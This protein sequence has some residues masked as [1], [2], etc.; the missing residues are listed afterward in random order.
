MWGFWLW[1]IGP[2][3][4][5]V[6]GRRLQTGASTCDDDVTGGLNGSLEGPPTLAQEGPTLLQ[7]TAHSLLLLLRQM[8]QMNTIVR[9]N[10]SMP[11]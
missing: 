10:D 3:S 7:D 5:A 4:A 9:Q 2:G 1:Q 6:A 8:L 11:Y